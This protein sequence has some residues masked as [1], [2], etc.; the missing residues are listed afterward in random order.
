MVYAGQDQSRCVETVDVSK[1]AE[2]ILE[3]LN[4]SVS[5]HVALRTD[6]AG[7][8][9]PVSGHAPKIRQVVMNLVINASEAIG[10]KHGAITLTTA[11]VRGD[12]DLCPDLPAGLP[13][14]DYVRLAVSD[15]GCG[16]TEEAAAKVFD[17]FFSTKVA[18]RG[19]GLAVVKGIVRDHAGTIDMTSVPGQ[20]TTFRVLL[21][22]SAKR[23][24]E[25]H[26]ECSSRP[27]SGDR[28]EPY[29]DDPGRR[30]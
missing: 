19:M 11:H 12:T 5:K 28:K 27:R 4:F 14:G 26:I 13:E 30:G 9:P 15:T 18:G 29:R 8:L 2:E 20:G 24:A 16:I 23:T 6:L 3:L 21:P 1:V 25:V 22:C 7:D 17:P 10:E